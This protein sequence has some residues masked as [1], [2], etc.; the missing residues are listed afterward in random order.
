MACIL[1]AEDEADI[2]IMVAEVLVDAGYLVVEAE[3]GD[4]AAL[5]LD[6]S[7]GFDFLVTDINMP[8]LLDGTTL[9]ANF[10]KLHAVRPILFITG[11]P[12]ALRNFSMQANREAVFQ[13]IWTSVA[14]RCCADDA[15]CC[16]IGHRHGLLPR[17]QFPNS[18]DCAVR[19]TGD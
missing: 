10:R 9:A 1:L 12:D 2:R 14:G 7:A 13:A 17:R 15:R 6:S 5:L 3:S 8:G 16:G 4:A 11:R 18:P 19:Q